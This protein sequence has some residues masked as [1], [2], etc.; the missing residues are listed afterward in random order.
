MKKK[1]AILGSTGSIGKCLLKI[2]E[3]DLK[4]FNVILLSAHKNYRELFIQARKFKVKNLIISDYESYCKAKVSSYNRNINIFNNFNQF[5]EIFKTKIDYTMSSIVG[6]DGLKP[7]LNIIKYTETIAIANK[8]SII[9]G[10][11]LISKKLIRYNTKFTPVDSE[12]FSI[13]SSLNSNFAIIEKIYLTASGGPF[14][15]YKFHEMKKI[16]INDA[17]NHPTWSMGKKISIDS[18]TLINKVFEVIE[19]KKIFNVNYNNLDILIHPNSYAHALIKFKNGVTKIIV[20]DTTMKI[21][22]F[23]SIYNHSSA[24]LRTKKID[25]KK[26]NSLNLIKPKK[27]KFPILGLINIL[28]NKDSL[29]ETVLV[30]ANDYL[31]NL[32]L[33]KKIPFIDIAL[34]LIKISKMKMF[35]KF[36]KKS[37]ASLSKILNTRNYTIEF[38]NNFFKKII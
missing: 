20:H 3:K 6:L 21:P 30:T 10:W 14:L 17:L 8:E 26:L 27:F 33:K 34:I 23:N 2:I 15:N 25:L 9:C 11:N 22:I 24:I 18:A 16:R 29:F 19:A 35:K 13:W 37:P 38:L 7:T 12:H 36:M 31:V 1:I 28:P 32:F 4:S 5:S